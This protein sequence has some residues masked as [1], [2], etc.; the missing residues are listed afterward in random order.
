MKNYL[1][2]LHSAQFP[3]SRSPIGS[4]LSIPLHSAI[5]SLI[6]CTKQITSSLH[7]LATLPL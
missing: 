4:G 1:P 5:M 3:A 2:S 6:R 7:S